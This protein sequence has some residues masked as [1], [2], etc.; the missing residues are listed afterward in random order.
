MQKIK[1]MS[2]FGTRPEA[3]KMAPIVKLMEQ[4]E[5]IDSQ[6]LVTAQHREMLDQ[7][8]SYF[9]IVPDYDLNLM[10]PNQS[11]A[12]VTSKIIEGVTSI[13]IKEK[14]DIILVHGDTTTTI[15][16]SI[17]A[18]YQKIK[19]GHVEAGLRTRN[20]YSPFPEEMNRQLTDVLSDIYFVPTEMSKNNL[21]KENKEKEKIF[22]TGNTSID[23]MKYTI[24]KNYYHDILALTEEKM[25]LVTMHRRESLGSP[26]RNVFKGIAQVA[27]K[28]PNISIVFPMHRNPK[29]REEARLI[30]GNF[31]NVFLIDPLDVVDFHNFA[32]KSY[33]ILTDSGGIQE[34][35]PYLN[36]PVLVLRDTTERPE[37]ILSG[38]LKIIG[39]N[40]A[41]VFNETVNLLENSEEYKLM[42]YSFNPYGDGKASYR[43]IEIL[44]YYF[45]INKDYPDEFHN[46]G[47]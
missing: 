41:S 44:K 40:E 12:S 15:A 20:K 22:V 11:L 31:P 39:T 43:I 4:D 32:K 29:V 34:E 6:V 18:F 46:T 17:A 21:I 30:L 19:I 36:V 38:T 26:M 16:S 33:L 13:L 47:S 45:G 3:V 42:K 9:D 7:I 1:V 10:A 8:L 28:Y 25:I 24:S 35:A 37:G 27:E 23:V 14:P 2:I 5:L